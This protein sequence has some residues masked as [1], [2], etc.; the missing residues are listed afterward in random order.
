MSKTFSEYSRFDAR[1]TKAQ[2]EF[3]EKAAYL[4]GYRNLT[5]FIVYTLQEKANEILKASEQIIV[6][7]RDGQIF[8]ESITNPP[9]PSKNLKK[10]FADYKAFIA[11]P[12]ISLHIE[13]ANT[14]ENQQQ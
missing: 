13:T 5:D 8:S 10:A 1:L 12:P 9:N 3:F 4:G 14:T 7:E 6:S 2:K 11:K